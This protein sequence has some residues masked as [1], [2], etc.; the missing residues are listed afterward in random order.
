MAMSV[1]REYEARRLRE[2]HWRAFAEACRLVWSAVRERLDAMSREIQFEAIRL[3]GEMSEADRTTP[4]FHRAV[5]LILGNA[6]RI[7]QWLEFPRVPKEELPGRKLAIRFEERL[8]IGDHSCR[9][10]G[11]CQR[12][13][14]WN[15]PV[16]FC[17]GSNPGGLRNRQEF[18]CQS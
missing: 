10:T 2:E 1:G 6:R 3:E 17:P 18:C 4:V 5:E 14:I 12:C 16:F 9:N 15:G 13:G 11:G 7:R 8:T